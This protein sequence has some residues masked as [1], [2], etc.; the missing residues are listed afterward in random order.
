ME[1]IVDAQHTF[2]I[3]IGIHITASACLEA[4]FEKLGQLVVGVGG[5]Q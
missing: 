2:A 1:S 4:I 3:A 5:R